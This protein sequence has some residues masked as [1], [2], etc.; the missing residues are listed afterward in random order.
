MAALA[1]SAET[2]RLLLEAG[3]DAAAR[4]ALLARHRERLRRMV[5]LRLDRR[6]PGRFTS[7]VILDEVFREAERRWAEYQARPE[8]SF[9]LWLRQLAGERI[10]AL[11]QQY[12]GGAWRGGEEITL[13]QDAMPRLN[14]ASLAAQLMGNVPAGHTVGRADLQI[15]LQEALNQMDAVDR[16]VLALCHFEE[17]NNDETAAVVGLDR[18]ETSRRYVQAVK[19]LKAILEQIP[20]F[21][22][23]SGAPTSQG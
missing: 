11:H 22:R 19:A 2:S 12:L 17:L 5:R 13:Y 8:A 20:G 14:T 16:E 21:F 23:K 4:E 10:Q 18:G 3:H 9:F 15:Y 7:S 6:V 1:N